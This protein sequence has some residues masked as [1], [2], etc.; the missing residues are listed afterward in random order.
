MMHL[1][2]SRHA[3]PEEA[4]KYSLPEFKHATLDEAHVVMKGTVEGNPT[5]DLIF[6]DENGQKYIVL[7]TANLL[8]MLVQASNDI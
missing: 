7:I 1:T 4:P 3:S 2:V 5:I 8:R 6:K